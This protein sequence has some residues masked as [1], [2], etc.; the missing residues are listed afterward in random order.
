MMILPAIKGLGLR[1]YH[2][3]S[4]STVRLS[5]LGPLFFIQ[6]LPHSPSWIT[7]RALNSY[8]PLSCLHP[9][10]SATLGSSNIICSFLGLTTVSSNGVQHSGSL[11]HAATAGTRSKES[12]AP[13]VSR[14]FRKNS[15]TWQ[16]SS[17]TIGPLNCHPITPM[18]WLLTS[19][20]AV[21]QGSI[22]PSSSQVADEFCFLVSNIG[23]TITS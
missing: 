13:N 15:D 3:R 8:S 18:T 22:Q 12:N 7:L 1:H 21:Q 6:S 11:C 9:S 2:S 4:K 16:G 19:S 14:P 5:P 17:A 10:S 23:F 20:Q